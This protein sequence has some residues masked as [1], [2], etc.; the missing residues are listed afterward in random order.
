MKTIAAV[1][2]FIFA[3]Q[4][5]ADDVMS[6]EQVE[7]GGMVSLSGQ[8]ERILDEDEFRL[9]D[10]TGSIRVYIGPNNM[11]VRQG[12]AVSVTGFVD[13]DLGPLEL[14]AHSLTTADGE[15]V[16]FSRRYY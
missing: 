12:D 14:Y 10:D 11:P 13:D 8:V 16:E 5:N 9:R 4:A 1:M 3:L 6:I 2:L 7:R 15:T